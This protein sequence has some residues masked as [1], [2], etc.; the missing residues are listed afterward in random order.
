MLRVPPFAALVFACAL[1][2]DGAV[3]AP[4]PEQ[5]QAGGRVLD[6][7]RG[8]GSEYAEAFDDHG[9]LVRPIELEEAGLLLAE[10]RDLVP[11]LG[12]DA[13]EVRRIEQAIT[14][15]ASQDAVSGLVTALAGRVTA[16]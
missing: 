1:C 9:T 13:A 11:R 16:A 3:A 15:R 7:L 8:V 4:T 6:L 12:I 14:D 5:V 10:A 2:A